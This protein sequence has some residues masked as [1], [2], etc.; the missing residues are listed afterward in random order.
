MFIPATTSVDFSKYKTYSWLNTH[1]PT[2]YYNDAIENNAKG[3]VDHI[4][5]SYELMVLP[6]YFPGNK[7]DDETGSGKQFYNRKEF[8]PPSSSTAL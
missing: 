5:K 3:F 8:N 6:H 7:F 4:E 1:K 2:P